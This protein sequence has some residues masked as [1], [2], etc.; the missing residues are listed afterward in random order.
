MAVLIE[1]VALDPRKTTIVGADSIAVILPFVVMDKVAH[2]AH[3]ERTISG[4]AV[5][6]AVGRRIVCDNQDAGMG[7]IGYVIMI[8]NGAGESRLSEFIIVRP[9]AYRVPVIPVRTPAWPA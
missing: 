7:P 1:S 5:I 3:V 6:S 4:V 8:N 2:D 9:N